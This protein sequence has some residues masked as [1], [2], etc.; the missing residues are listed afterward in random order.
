MPSCEARNTLLLVED[1]A[2]IRLLLSMILG[3]VGYD[4]QVAADGFSALRSMRQ[5]LP[6]IILSDLNM[7]GMSGYELL[8]VVR[9][10]F[11]AIRVIAMSAS[12][13]G[14]EIPAGVAADG[15]YQKGSDL[16]DLL[17]LLNPT[18]D[19]LQLCRAHHTLSSVP[20]WIAKNGPDPAGSPYIT[21]SCPECLRTFPQSVEDTSFAIHEAG[22][23]YCGTPVRYAIVQTAD[24]ACL[25]RQLTM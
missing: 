12:Y 4:V 8:S 2:Q 21:V 14:P 10:R 9:R 3:H 7:P 19:G 22:C 5:T 13:S 16:E 17:S 11:P 1:D 25:L 15:F 23:I 20:L 6:E 18:P 24:T